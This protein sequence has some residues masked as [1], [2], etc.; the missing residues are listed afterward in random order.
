MTDG[1]VFRQAIHD[2][3]LLRSRLY[4]LQRQGSTGQKFNTPEQD[5]IATERVRLIREAE[6]AAVHY[7][8]NITRSRTQLEAADSALGE[9][10]NLLIRAKELAI[11]MR[12]ATVSPEQ[13]EIGAAEVRSLFE[14]MVGLA[15]TQAGGEYVFGGFGTSSR[16]FA[17]DGTFVGDTGVKEVDVGPGAR[18]TVNVSGAAAF[19]AAG[20][21][22]IFAEIDE[23]A[24]ALSGNDVAGIDQAIGTVE[25]ALTQISR[26]RT[27]AG[28][29]LNQLDVASSVRDRIEDSLGRE[30]SGIMDID[31]VAV[32]IDLNATAQALE[33]ALAVSQKVSSLSILGG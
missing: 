8:K 17:D 19:T 7:G 28:L 18:L 14:S 22:D 21:V 16:P 23:L 32:F 15:N 3:S 12:N 2:V 25:Q 20:G 31:P 26:S 9:A 33:E 1:I 10:S 6:Q 4:D 5:P 24:T 29:K 11:G 13:R 27:D 30:E